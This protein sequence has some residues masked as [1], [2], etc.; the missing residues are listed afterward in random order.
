[1]SEIKTFL[2]LE[3][4]VVSV[5]NVIFY[6]KWFLTIDFN[7]CYFQDLFKRDVFELRERYQNSMFSTSEHHL[8]IDKD[9]LFSISSEL[10]S[11]EQWSSQLDAN[12]QKLLFTLC[13]FASIRSD[14]WTKWRFSPEMPNAKATTRQFRDSLKNR[15]S[16]KVDLDDAEGRL[17]D[18]WPVPNAW[19]NAALSTHTSLETWP[20]SQDLETQFSTKSTWDV[21]LKNSEQGSSVSWNFRS[22]ITRR[23]N[24]DCCWRFLPWWRLMDFWSSS[25]AAERI[26]CGQRLK[27]MSNLEFDNA[28][29]KKSFEF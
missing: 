15:F 7:F 19:N 20:S 16:T 9:S 5:G 2:F 25:L 27:N 23:I 1:M 8:A 21:I 6:L 3:C 24:S 22:D 11:L 26:I 13:T 12:C 29:T 10:P 28:K 18:R 14:H 4:Q 17:P